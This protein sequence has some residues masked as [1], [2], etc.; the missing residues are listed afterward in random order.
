MPS[1]PITSASPIY[2]STQNTLNLN[3]GQSLKLIKVFGNV[4]SIISTPALHD[5]F[6]VK[7]EIIP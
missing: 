4:K 7:A 1:V 3:H 5:W 2:S 6:S